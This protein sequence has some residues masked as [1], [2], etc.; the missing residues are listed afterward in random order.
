MKPIRFYT[1][2]LMTMFATLG[3][4]THQ[5]QANRLTKKFQEEFKADKETLLKIDNRFGQ[6]S[7]ENW[8]N[9]SISIEVEVTV[10]HTSRDRAERMLSAIDISLEKVGN[11]VRGITSIDERIMRS[12]GNVFNFSSSNKEISIDYTIK[13]PKHLSVNLKNKY[14]DIFIDELTGHAEIDLKY[15]NMKANRIL[16]GS[17]SPLSMLT[18]GYGNASIDEIDWM[19]FDI[20]YAN[21]DIVKGT[22]MVVLSKY[23]KIG[24]SQVSSMVVESKYDTYTI[25]TIAN[26]VGESGY[27]TYRVRKLG[28]KLDIRTRYGDVRIDEVDDGFE[29]IAFVGNYASLYAP[30]SSNV[31]Y[32]FDGEASYGGLNYHTP[33]RVNRTERTN[34]LAVNGTVGE[35]E[36]PNASVKVRVRYGSARLR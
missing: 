17:N 10:E 15:G 2:I 5:V 31:S 35:K 22:A 25:G 3:L 23:S 12:L 36:N 16:Y 24:V 9:N 6:V 11:E 30:I 33:A 8:D 1:I 14:G 13:M 27:T 7:I 28:K 34:S 29:S 32:N 20:K 4:A 18:L 19:R 26:I 21:L